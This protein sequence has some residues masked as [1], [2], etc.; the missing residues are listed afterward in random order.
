LS[1]LIS[2]NLQDLFNSKEFKHIQNI[3]K[4]ESSFDFNFEKNKIPFNCPKIPSNHPEP[5]DATK[6]RF[7]DIKVQMALGDSITAGFSMVSKKN[8]T[9][10][11]E[12]RKLHSIHF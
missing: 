1:F 9:T 4:L 10:F 12:R 7:S 3:T 11:S 8:L 6:L 2:F 5:E